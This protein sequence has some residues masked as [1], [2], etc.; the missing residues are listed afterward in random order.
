MGQFQ[1][2]TYFYG[3]QGLQN[4][5]I[6]NDPKLPAA[7]TPIAKAAGGFQWVSTSGAANATYLEVINDVSKLFG[8]ALNR[9]LGVID[10]STPFKLCMSPRTSIALTF[11]ATLG[12]GVSV[13]DTLK[14]TYPGIRAVVAPQ[15][16][17]A[18]G[19]LVQLL[20][21]E[22]DGQVTAQTAFNEKMRAHGV[23]RMASSF[24]EKKSAGTWGA[25]YYTYVGV[26]Q[27]LGV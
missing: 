3:V 26:A 14:K 17:T 4:Y 27:M 13:W 20:V 11:V 21:D 18:S 1:N 5:G 22:V 6:L 2:K 10:T 16:S 25:I 7:I 8:D 9:S 19:E 23:V 24:K 12:T 15:Y